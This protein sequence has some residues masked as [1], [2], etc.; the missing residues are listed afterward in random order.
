MEDRI[1]HG[2]RLLRVLLQDDASPDSMVVGNVQRF[3]FDN[4]T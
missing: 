4:D 2:R 1:E 3:D